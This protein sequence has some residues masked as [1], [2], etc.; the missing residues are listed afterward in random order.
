MTMTMIAHRARGK[1]ISLHSNRWAAGAQAALCL[2]TQLAQAVHQILDGPLAHA[3]NA[4][5]HK[6]PLARCRHCSRQGPV[7][8]HRYGWR[9][10][11]DL[12]N[13]SRYS[14][15]LKWQLLCTGRSARPVGKKK[16]A[17]S[18]PHGS[19]SVA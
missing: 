13:A 15:Q 1:S 16:C 10:V 7:Q 5:Q 12:L 6:S 14:V 17:Q 18:S 19:A 2:H 11:I 3:R 4:I 8:E 9:V